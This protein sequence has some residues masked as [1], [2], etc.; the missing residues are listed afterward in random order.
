MSERVQATK[1]RLAQHRFWMIGGIIAVLFTALVVVLLYN[2]LAAS[3]M[4]ATD[5]V[6]VLLAL[7]FLPPL[8]LVAGQFLWGVASGANVILKMGSF[9]LAIDALKKKVDNQAEIA[10]EMTG[11]LSTAEQTLYPMV[12]GPNAFAR[13]RL[14]QGR[15]VIGSKDFAANIVVAELLAQHL[16][17]AGMKIERRIPNGGTVTNYAY[18]I[19][20]W[21][22]LFVD[23]TG[24]G[25]LF[26]NVEYRGRTVDDILNDLNRLSRERFEVEW[27]KPLGTRT[28]YCLVM[29]DDVAEGKDI[30][31]ISD[32][33]RHRGKLRFCGNHE[34]LNRR[35]GLPGLK[36]WYGL[37][38]LNEAVCSYTERYRLV[39]EGEI[40]VSV[41]H[42][43]DPEIRHLGLR[44]LVDNKTFF[45]EYFEV[46]IARTEALEA[47][48]GLRDA[49]AAFAKIGI[50]DEDIT[51]LIQD[52]RD[53]ASSLREEAGA[54]LKR[55]QA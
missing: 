3:S 8:L 34:F 10:Q 49:L 24:T 30:R 28:N 47:V 35:D 27:M 55:R 29:R 46:P 16:D 48:P 4:R 26:L 6:L 9:Q 25:C 42:T 40:D 22:D 13:R 31:E 20:G 37:R 39:H 7:L 5:H 36:E 1:K 38:F 21:I 44:Q 23:Y 18:L 32:I 19:N 50:K 52:F 45:P 17:A 14:E 2:E 15:V 51:S 41:G 54:L 43:T 33:A 11:K 12:G 53:E